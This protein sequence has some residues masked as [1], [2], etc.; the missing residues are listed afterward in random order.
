MKRFILVPLLCLAASAQA[1]SNG[2]YE[3]TV[4]QA[5]PTVYE[6]VSKSLEAS[7]F[8]VIQKVDIG[9]NLSKLAPKLGDQYNLSKLESIQSMI[10]CNG[11][12]AN[13]ISNADPAMLALCPL[14]ITLVSKA[15][16]TSALF[17]RP[18]QV[19]AGSPAAKAAQDLEDKV[20]KAIETGLDGK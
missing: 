19:A 6:E 10:F 15:G 14:H 20:I 11:P 7:G 18:G 8:R 17:V 12:A 5:L 3:K 1:A 13:Q 2:V 4:P 9:E 16:A